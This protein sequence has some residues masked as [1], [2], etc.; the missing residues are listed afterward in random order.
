RATTIHDTALANL[1]ALA[2]Y[3]ITALVLTDFKTAIDNFAAVIEAPQLKQNEKKIARQNLT[4]L[5]NTADTYLKRIDKLMPQY[6]TAATQFYNEYT[7]AR[8]IKDLG[9]RK[10][11]LGLFVELEDGVDSTGVVVVITKGLK[12]YTQ[13]VRSTDHKAYFESILI[14]TYTITIHHP[15]YQPWTGTINIKPGILNTATAKLM[16]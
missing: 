6:R 11:R 13:T 3:N 1:A 10:T 5:L 4:N 15:G 14:G 8:Q 16:L 12:N 2:P 9:H 7:E